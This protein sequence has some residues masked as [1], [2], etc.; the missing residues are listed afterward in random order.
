LNLAKVWMAILAGSAGRKRAEAG[1]RFAP[2]VP[3]EIEE[4]PSGGAAVSLAESL[5]E[6][7]DREFRYL[8]V[9]WGKT[10]T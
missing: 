8:F 4:K 9:K 1:S 3:A 10:I 7:S 5:P 6:S 2:Q